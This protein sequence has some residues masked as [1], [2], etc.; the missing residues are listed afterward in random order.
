MM[1]ADQAIVREATVGLLLDGES[2]VRMTVMA[3][4]ADGISGRS[5][6]RHHA[7]ANDCHAQLVA[8]GRAARAGQRHPRRPQ[9]AA[10]TVPRGRRRRFEEVIASPFDGS[11]AQSLFVV[12]REGRKFAVAA[13]LIKQ[14]I[15]VRDAW[16]RRG[17]S[18]RELDAFL[19]QVAAQLDL[20]AVTLDHV[21][22]VTKHFLAVGAAGGVMPPFG[23][24]D[25]AETIGMSDLNPADRPIEDVV[26]ALFAEVGSANRTAEATGR[27]IED[28]ARWPED[29]PF[30]ADVV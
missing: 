23:L 11:G 14:G 27:L 4:L 17:L 13:L 29:Y 9:S 20:W 18:R 21:R 22:V 28:S 3:A 7:A 25:V 15:G 26:D 19:A 30:T 2:S 16:V 6:H 8:G 24:V 5:R 12:V 10:S 1:Q